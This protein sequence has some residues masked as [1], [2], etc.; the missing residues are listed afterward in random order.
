MPRVIEIEAERPLDGL[1]SLFGLSYMIKPVF[2]LSIFLL[3]LSFVQ[4]SSKA[5]DVQGISF[6]DCMNSSGGVT[7]EM[8]DCC[9]LE[10]T[11]QE[12]IIRKTNEDLNTKLPSESQKE[13]LQTSQKLWE[14]YRQIHC[15]V[16]LDPDGGSASNLVYNDCLVTETTR[17]A[18]ELQEL[19][20]NL[21]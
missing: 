3:F 9:S 10:L 17:R 19:L 4:S 21:N 16:S 8:L 6:T 18:R 15:L 1:L 12:Q 2:V 14:N 5:D 13:A 7:S 20:T 11:K